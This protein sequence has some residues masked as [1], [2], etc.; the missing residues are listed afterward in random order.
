MSV[1]DRTNSSL[2]YRRVRPVLLMLL[3]SLAISAW[4]DLYAQPAA[5]TAEPTQ[6]TEQQA[7]PGPVNQRQA[8]ERVRARY[9]GNVISINEVRQGNR[10]RYRVRIDNEGNIFTVFVDQATGRISRE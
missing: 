10:V 2:S 8:L 4:G 5:A 1:K 3:F 9:P 7:A 6:E